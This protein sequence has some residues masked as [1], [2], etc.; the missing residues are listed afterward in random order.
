MAIA[1]GCAV[2]ARAVLVV[3]G[4]QVAHRGERVAGP[5]D[6]VEQHR[7]GDREARR[8]RLGLGG[9]QPFERRLAPRHEPLGR[10][11]AHEL[12]QLLRVVA[13]LGDRLLVLD[14]V[15]RCLHDDRA[16]GVEA[17]PAGATGDLVELPDLR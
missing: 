4:E 16:G 11:L 5:G 9:H 2:V 6:H 8:E 15:L 14:V 1:A 10:L 13:G 17:G 12:A 3:V 7:V